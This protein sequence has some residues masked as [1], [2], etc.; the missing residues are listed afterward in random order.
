MINTTR[1][2]ICSAFYLK[3]ILW[4]PYPSNQCETEASCALKGDKQ[5]VTPKWRF[6][7][8]NV[9]RVLVLWINSLLLVVQKKKKVALEV[10]DV[11]VLI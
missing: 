5:F 8:N 1:L 9:E 3:H 10:W 2:T 6:W 11:L 4:F 7:G